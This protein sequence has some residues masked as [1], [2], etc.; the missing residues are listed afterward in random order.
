MSHETDDVLSE[1]AV[2]LVS[3]MLGTKEDITPRL[4]SSGF[5]VVQVATLE[6]ALEKIEK[7]NSNIVLCDTDFPGG[8]SGIKFFH[9]IRA[10]SKF[11]Y[12]PFILVGEVAEIAQLKSS[13]LKPNEGVIKRPIGYEELTTIMNDKLTTFRECIS[14]PR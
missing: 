7:V 1:G 11:N 2:L 6:N 12:I 4:K 9:V 10:N 13:E 14:S 8:L 3:K 5:A